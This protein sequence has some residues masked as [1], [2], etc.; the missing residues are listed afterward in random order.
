VHQR[1]KRHPSFLAPVQQQTLNQPEKEQSRWKF[2][3]FAAVGVPVVFAAVEVALPAPAVA[4]EAGPNLA[5]IRQSHHPAMEEEPPFEGLAAAVA[6]GTALNRLAVVQELVQ[7]A[8]V[9]AAHQGIVQTAAAAAVVAAV[10]ELE[11]E[12]VAVAVVVP[13][14]VQEAAVA[15]V[16]PD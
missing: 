6:V 10:P 12:V 1:Q 5:D 4:Q 3:T 2:E 8:V 13:E 16:V 11:Q 9:V 15:A 7:V 14:Q